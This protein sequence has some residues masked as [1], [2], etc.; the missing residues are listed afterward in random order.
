MNP[1]WS[2]FSKRLNEPKQEQQKGPPRK[3]GGL[4]ALMRE[5]WANGRFWFTYAAR[6]PVDVD[7]LFTP[8]SMGRRWC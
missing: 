8:T 1:D 3:L 7:D 5:S 6:R 4:S 2:S